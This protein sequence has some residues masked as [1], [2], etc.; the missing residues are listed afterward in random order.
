MIKYIFILFFVLFL[1]NCDNKSINRNIIPN[2]NVIRQT[3]PVKCIVKKIY[4]SVVIDDEVG[5][6][7][8]YGTECKDVIISKNKYKINDTILNYNCDKHK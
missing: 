4:P 8:M 6:R 5:N 3:T 1:F 7:Y 2:T